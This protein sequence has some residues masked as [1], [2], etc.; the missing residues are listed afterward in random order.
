MRPPGES[1]SSPSSTKVGQV[2]LQKPQCTQARRIFSASAVAGFLSCASEKF[3]CIL[4]FRPHAPG[5]QN[6]VR[7]ESLLQSPR[8]TGKP[9]GLRLEDRDFCT[10][11]N[12]PA[13]KGRVAATILRDSLT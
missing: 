9:P 1:S 11:L 7:I 6:G 5:L 10:Q 3:V 8:Q 2:A 4:K 12:G 13:D